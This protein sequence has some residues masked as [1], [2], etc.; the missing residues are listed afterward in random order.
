MA[1]TYTRPPRSPNN[2]SKFLAET[3][4]PPWEK[5]GIFLKVKERKLYEEKPTDIEWQYKIEH[6]HTQQFAEVMIIRSNRAFDSQSFFP[7]TWMSSDNRGFFICPG[8]QQEAPFL[9]PPDIS[10]YLRSAVCAYLFN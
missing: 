5:L 1:I 7:F 2:L 6:C 4:L 10:F 9:C 3:C 8:L